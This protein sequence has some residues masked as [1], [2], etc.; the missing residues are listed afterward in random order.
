MS[1]SEKWAF[2]W[3]HFGDTQNWG[4]NEENMWKKAIETQHSFQ[5]INTK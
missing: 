5:D 3:G 1:T 2:T 4:K